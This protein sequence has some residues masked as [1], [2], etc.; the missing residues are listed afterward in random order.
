MLNKIVLTI[1]AL[2]RTS[3]RNALLLRGDWLNFI[4]WPLLGVL[5]IS[6]L[7]TFYEIQ[8]KQQENIV[9]TN[10]LEMVSAASTS[11]ALQITRSLQGLNTLMQY[12]ADDLENGNR[13]LR[14]ENLKMRG[15]FDAKPYVIVAVI[16]QD[17]FNKTTTVPHASKISVLDRNYFQFHRDHRTTLLRI[18]K[19][20]IGRLS[21]QPLIQVTR[22]LNKKDGSFDGVLLV[23][24]EEDFFISSSYMINGLPIYQTLIENN[25]IITQSNPLKSKN[26]ELFYNLNNKSCEPPSQPSVLPGICFQDNISRYIAVAS[27]PPYQYKFVV[28]LAEKEILVPLL[29]IEEARRRIL[30]V[31]S[32]LIAAFTLFAFFTTIKLSLKDAEASNIRRAYRI[33]TENG[34]EG[35][36][37]WKRILNTAGKVVD[38]KI[39]D[40]NEYGA[41]LY[42][43]SKKE[44]IGKTITD[45]YGDT[46]YCKFVIETG[47]QMDEE[48]DGETEFE[49]P[50][51]TSILQPTWIQRKHARTYEGVAVTI[52]DISDKKLSEIKLDQLANNDTLTGIPNR[53]W[54]MTS[55]PIFLEKAEKSNSSV[56]LFFIDL[57]NF[58]DINDSLGHAAGDTVLREVA[59]RITEV[60]REEDRVIRLGGDEFTVIL[61][62]ASDPDYVSNIATRLIKSFKTPFT[63]NNVKKFISASIG[64]AR[65]PNDGS[66]AEALIQKADMAMYAAKTVKGQFLFFNEELLQRRGRIIKIEDEL[67]H[68]VKNDEFI[69]YY[70]PRIGAKSGILVGFEALVRWNSTTRGLVEPLEFISLAENSDL[71][72]L[73][74][75]I[76]IEKVAQQIKNWIDSGLD[77]VPI[78]VNVSAKQFSASDMS[79][80]I[81]ACCQKESIAASHIEVEITESAMMG[82]EIET[83]A[84][85]SQLAKMGIK[86]HVDDFGT[87]YSSLSMLRRLSMDVL[88]ID[89]AFTMELGSSKECEILYRTMISMAHAL[90]MTV[91]AEGVETQEQMNILRELD[92]DELQGYLISRPLPAVEAALFLENRAAVQ[93]IF[94][95]KRIG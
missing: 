37:L 22:R 89:R 4:M 42:K 29:A 2:T 9:R 12:I 52:R 16:G 88:K 50:K 36:Y 69:V 81:A 66:D 6:A 63:I 59:Q 30:L 47:I 40:C 79:G 23:G 39:V 7:W 55:L 90:G 15:V 58:K 80:V 68:A 85:L 61:N 94:W 74:G 67:R 65:Y 45:M 91:V 60:I 82:S 44:M 43:M 49:I 70:Q 8:W 32:A 27:L 64:I 24:V 25:N 38:F 19:P 41:A 83:L 34:K 10:T 11:Y 72:I 93:K 73:I 3:K 86:T 92:C 84:Q 1:L 14:L 56:A 54:M 13:Y 75:V 33:A 62:N 71:I 5:S 31:C 95:P 48:G 20:V 21:K 17:G 51:D 76:V 53:H 28:G 57:D 78:S 77:V 26:S 35:F 87:G 46:P 18:S